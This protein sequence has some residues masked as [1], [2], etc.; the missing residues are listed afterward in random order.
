[1]V[2]ANNIRLN[3]KQ[4]GDDNKPQELNDEILACYSL[5]RFALM[6]MKPNYNVILERIKKCGERNNEFG[7]F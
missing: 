7:G 6:D 2:I 4:R 5:H 1:M 3:K